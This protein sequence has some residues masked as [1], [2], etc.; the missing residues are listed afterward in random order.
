M[1]TVNQTFQSSITCII[2]FT[3]IH[4]KVVLC[5][6]VKTNISFRAKITEVEWRMSKDVSELI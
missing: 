4:M 5:E 6:E 1:L 2:T 3:T